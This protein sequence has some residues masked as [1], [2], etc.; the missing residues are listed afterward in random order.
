LMSADT[1]ENVIKYLS[2]AQY[3]LIKTFKYIIQVG[4]QFSTKI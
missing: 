3:E 4:G 2:S 1:F